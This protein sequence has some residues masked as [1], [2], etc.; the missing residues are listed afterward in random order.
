MIKFWFSSFALALGL[1][2]MVALSGCIAT[3]TNSASAAFSDSERKLIRENFVPQPLPKVLVYVKVTQPCIFFTQHPKDGSM[4]PVGMLRGD[5]YVIV[6]RNDGEW[7]D[8]QLDDGHRGSVISSNIRHLTQKERNRGDY[9]YNQPDL[10]PLSLPQA[11]GSGPVSP[12]DPT[13]LGG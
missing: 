4:V 13:L 1:A 7:T 3:E 11:S 9:L 6:R 5:S 2:A 10:E 12:L 8:V